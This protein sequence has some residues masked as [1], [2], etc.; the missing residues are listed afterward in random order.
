MNKTLFTI[1]AM[2]ILFSLSGCQS[3]NLSTEKHFQAKG[4][5]HNLSQKQRCG[6]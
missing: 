2:T 5:I 3:A 4:P 1:L 6:C